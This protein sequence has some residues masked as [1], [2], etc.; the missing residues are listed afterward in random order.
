M[1]RA[2]L[3]VTSF[4]PPATAS[5]TYRAYALSRSS[6]SS[7]ATAIRCGQAP[8][9]LNTVVRL[10]SSDARPS[11]GDGCRPRSGRLVD[12]REVVITGPD[13]SLEDLLPASTEVRRLEHKSAPYAPRGS[14]P[15]CQ[16]Y[17]L[18]IHAEAGC[19]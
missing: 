6:D 9:T 1:T 4:S 11:R 13:G 3:A 19:P 12:G 7:W 10:D 2:S 14:L 15:A 17:S 8:A 18:D 5:L 16:R